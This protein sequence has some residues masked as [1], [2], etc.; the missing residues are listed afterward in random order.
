MANGRRVSLFESCHVA[1]PMAVALV[2]L[3]FA[4]CAPPPGV[5][6]VQFLAMGTNVSITIV[7]PIPAGLPTAL[8]DIEVQMQRLGHEWYPW[9]PD[10]SGELAQVNASIAEGKTREVSPELASLL[11]TAQSLAAASDG[12]FDPAVGSLVELWGFTTGMRDTATLPDRVVLDEWVK[13]HP[14]FADLFIQGTT[15]GS[16]NRM[17]KLD[18]GAIAKGRV[19]DI[20]VSELQKAGV[21][22]ALVTAGGNV[23]A[24]GIAPEHPWR[25]AIRDPRGPGILGWVDLN[26]GESIDTSG[27]YERFAIV[28]GRRIHHLLDPRTGSPADHTAAITVIAA[29]GTLADAAATALF[30]AGPDAWREVARQL[31]ID[32][33][34]RIDTAGRMEATSSMAARVSWNTGNAHALTIVD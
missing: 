4:A 22:H 19:V 29:N 25:I 32:A 8:S 17:L 10:G 27:D 21:T 14:T 11:A 31:G 23:H 34:L 24:L 9:T 6:T 16:R 1:L 33:V 3:S 30:V 12:R 18:L 26:D 13:A 28:D 7:E 20:A 2:C 5:H 15:V